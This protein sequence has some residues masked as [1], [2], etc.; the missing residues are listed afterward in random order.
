MTTNIEQ[1]VEWYDWM[2]NEGG[3]EGII[4]HGHNGTGDNLLDYLL[5]NLEM[6]LDKVDTRINKIHTDY[7]DQI[8]AV[9]KELGRE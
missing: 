3:I 4:R 8:D 2:D 1:F 6:W 7:R 5:E 9:Y